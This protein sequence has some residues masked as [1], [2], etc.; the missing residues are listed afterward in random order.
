MDYGFGYGMIKL[1]KE[2][3]PYGIYHVCGSGKTSWYGFA[4]K[5]FEYMDLNTN[6]IPIPTEEFP[7]PAKRPEYSVINNNNICPQWEESLQNIYLK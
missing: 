3:T 4:K 6:V 5:I 7:R 1:I 2:N